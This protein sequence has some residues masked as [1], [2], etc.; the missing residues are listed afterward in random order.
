[1]LISRYIT[2]LIFVISLLFSTSTPAEE[3]PTFIGANECRICHMP[4]YESWSET[5][6]SKAF[7]LLKPGARTEAKKKVGLDPDEDYTKNPGC[8]IC[9]TTGF[10]R[11]GGF[12]SMEKTPDMANVQCEM[13][14]G[15]GSIYAEMMQKAR[16]TYK[17]EDYI[18]K[19][20]LML[21]SPKMNIC[22][23]QCH[24]AAS[25]FVRHD[26]SFNFDDRKAIG[27]HKHNLQY[28]YMPF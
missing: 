21:P 12:I 6:M 8:L 9:H 14:H 24:N 11:P 2:A 1:M 13:C 27:T 5:R 16:G 23:A 17:R 7:D 4:H 10:G 26:Y 18:K 20:K 25:P 28:I 3:Q 19:G 22:A 15:P